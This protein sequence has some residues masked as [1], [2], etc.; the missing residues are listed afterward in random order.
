[1]SL[2]EGDGVGDAAAAKAK[3]AAVQA[4][5]I[6]SL[7]NGEG[8]GDPNAPLPSTEATPPPGGTSAATD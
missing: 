7:V 4:G 3:V 5:E 8:Q 1:H 6:A 2:A